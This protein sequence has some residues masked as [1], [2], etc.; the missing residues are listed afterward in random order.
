MDCIQIRY[1]Q[2]KKSL[3][4]A[5]QVIW[6]SFTKIKAFFKYKDSHIGSANLNFKYLISDSLSVTKKT[7]E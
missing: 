3:N 6:L 5:F 4:K 7:L 1:Q 2:H